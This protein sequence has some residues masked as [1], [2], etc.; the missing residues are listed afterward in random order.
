[1]TIAP[2]EEQEIL[3]PASL[4]EAVKAFGDGSSVTVLGGG[5]ILMAEITSGRVRADRV[6]LLGRAGLDGFTEEGGLLRIGATVRVAAL[7]DAVEPL[8]SAARSVAD[9][10]IRGQ[11]TVGGNLCAPRGSDFPRG[12]LQAA[13]IALGARVRTAGA[14]GERT[15]PVEE[16]LPQRAGRLVL[17]IEIETAGRRGAWAALDRPHTHS[18]TPLAVAAATG[19]GDEFRVAAG[20]VGAHALQLP[21]VERAG[22]E[23]TGAEA[24]DDVELADDA[25]ASAW[26]RK[27]MLP[28]LVRRALAQLKEQ[29]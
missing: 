16:F 24:L 7:E 29:A 10:E 26:Y 25:L 23:A 8:G 28:V 14:G 15:E 2:L 13:L 5:T 20:G 11:A 21:S 27:R 3:Q 12:D 6:L 4:E 17:D 1:M 9:L 19:P 22:L 18:Y